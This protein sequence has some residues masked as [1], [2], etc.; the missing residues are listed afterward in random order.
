[1]VSNVFHSQQ[2][3]WNTPPGSFSLNLWFFFNC[4]KIQ[5][6]SSVLIFVCKVP[7][8]IYYLLTLPPEVCLLYSFE[9]SHLLST[10]EKWQVQITYSQIVHRCEYIKI[11]QSYS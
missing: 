9:Y 4:L 11:E 7:L 5:R 2:E 8:H 1:M 6:S 3:F 10:W